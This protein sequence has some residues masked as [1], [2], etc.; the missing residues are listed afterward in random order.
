MLTTYI[1]DNDTY[2][3]Q[4]KK[5]A[6]EGSFRQREGREDRQEDLKE[7]SICN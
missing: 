2:N 1:R 5:Q 6:Q 4:M 7:N 3:T